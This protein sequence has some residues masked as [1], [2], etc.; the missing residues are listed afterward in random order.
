[1]FGDEDVMEASCIGGEVAALGDGVAIEEKEVVH[2][3]I[4]KGGGGGQHC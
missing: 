3:P 1:M 2:C 4:V